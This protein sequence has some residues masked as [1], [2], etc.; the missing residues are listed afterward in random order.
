MSLETELAENT[1]AINKLNA[2]ILNSLSFIGTTTAA[3]IPKITKEKPTTKAVSEKTGT[4][5][6]TQAVEAVSRTSTPLT[7]TTAPVAELVDYSAIKKAI[8]D[9]ST[10]RGREAAVA[11]LA[12]FGATKGTDLNP[13]QYGDFV[14]SAIQANADSIDKA[15]A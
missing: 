13:A 11:L 8:T 2:T 4:P 15:L 9:L 1:A 6:E 14:A 10:S 7:T 3:A 5:H 12:Q